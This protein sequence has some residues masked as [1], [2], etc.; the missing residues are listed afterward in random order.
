PKP[1]ALNL[2]EPEQKEERRAVVED[3]LARAPMLAV[4]FKAVPGNTPDFYAPQILSS[5]PTGGQSSR[6]YQKLVKEK[7][8]ANSVRGSMDERHGAGALSVVAF[9]SPGKSAEAVKSV[10]YEEIERLRREPVSDA[11]LQKAKNV[12]ALSFNSNLQTSLSRAIALGQYKVVYDDPNL[13]NTRLDKTNAVTR[14]DVLRVAQKYLRPTNR[15]VVVTTPKAKA[16]TGG[17]AGR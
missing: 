13:I 15:T 10:I 9:P 7:E 12:I 16:A 5:V 4:A 2:A 14:E 3:A 6:L 17:A 11:E 8:L 1:V